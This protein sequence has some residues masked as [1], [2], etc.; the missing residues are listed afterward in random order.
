MEENNRK[1]PGVFY[2]VVGVATLVVAII[3][4]TLAY[5]AASKT[6]TGTITGR[7]LN[8]SNSDLDLTVTK[9]NFT[10]A[11]VNTNL[12]P[13]LIGDSGI[14]DPDSLTA[15]DISAMVG[16]SCEEANKYTGC[17]V[18]KITAY[19]NNTQDAITHANLW[20]TLSTDA[21]D[22]DQWGYAVFEA[23]DTPAGTEPN[24]TSTLTGVSYATVPS[25]TG[26]RANHGSL[27]TAITGNTLDMHNDASLAA[28]SSKTYY[29]M[30]YLNDDKAVQN[31]ATPAT[32]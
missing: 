14:T 28:N 5:Y 20:L 32:G 19:N 23:T 25:G 6:N 2:A 3:G 12:A 4:A 26:L 8:I 13:A 22:K 15:D 18:W 11:T 16:A 7:T 30:V 24:V 10:G 31:A 21:T 17:H 27:A 29:L 1:G 9:V